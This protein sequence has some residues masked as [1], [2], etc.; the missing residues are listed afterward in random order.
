MLQSTYKRAGE[1]CVV[2]FGHRLEGDTLFCPLLF[3]RS[4]LP[5]RPYTLR[6]VDTEA[7]LVVT[8]PPSFLGMAKDKRVSRASIWR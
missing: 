6:D 8:L 4:H 5:E 1:P 3:V 2:A 7:R